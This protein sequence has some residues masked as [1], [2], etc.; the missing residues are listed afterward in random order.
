MTESLCADERLQ[1]IVTLAEADAATAIERINAM[2]V[3]HPQDPRLHFL[4]GS[5]LIEGGQL[6]DAHAALF[7]A[8]E[9]APDFTIARFQL[10]LFE[11]TSGEADRAVQTWAPLKALSDTH[12]LRA[13][14]TGLEH[15]IADRF[16]ACIEALQTGIA[17]NSENLPLNRDMELIIAQCEHVVSCA[18]AAAPTPTDEV[19]APKLLLG[20]KRR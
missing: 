16:A 7:R 9:I 6:F 20:S 2:L 14:V 4:K 10:G 12:F 18:P 1:E 15:L 19:S 3:D 11:L 5:L 8:V 13:F 17:A